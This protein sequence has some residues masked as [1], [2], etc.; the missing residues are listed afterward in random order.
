MMQKNS[1][2]V[3]FAQGI[4]SKTDPK[5]LQI[6][7]FTALQNSVFTN[8]GLLQKRNGFKT[9]ASLPGGG[10]YAYLNTFN[11]DL[12]AIGQ[13]I[14][15]YSEP[16]TSW[17]TKGNYQP[18][19]LSVLPVIRNNLNQVS[20]DIAIAPNGLGCVV[21]NEQQAS[22]SGTITYDLKFAIFDSVTGQNIV[23]P[24]LV[25]IVSGGIAPTGSAVTI[26][27][28]IF[29]NYFVIINEFSVGGN[30]KLQY[31]A[32]PW[33]TPASIGTPTSLGLE[34]NSNNV[35]WDA[36]VVPGGDLYLAY[37]W[38]TGTAVITIHIQSS[39]SVVAS[40]VISS[41]AAV[42]SLT[43]DTTSTPVIYLNYYVGSGGN[44]YMASYGPTLTPILS[45]LLTL[46]STVVVNMTASAQ[47]G[48]CFMFYE[49]TNSYGYDNA[50]PT[51]FVGSVWVN[52]GAVITPAYVVLRGVGLAS[53]SYIYSGS[54]YFLAAYS[55]P[56]QPTYFLVTGYNLTATFSTE[57]AP[58]IVAKLAYGNGGG[59]LTYG[60]PSVPVSGNTMYFGYLFKDL[61]QSVN[62]NT[63]PPAGSQVNGIYTQ[64]GINM[65][66]VVF[67][68]STIDVEEIGHDMHLSGGFLWMYDGYLPVE[69]NFFLWPDSIEVVANATVSPTG[70]VTM[71]GFTISSVSSLTNV[72]PGQFVSGTGIPS[73]TYITAVDSLGSD[74]TMSNAAT[75]SHSG[76]TLTIGG[77]EDTSYTY[78]YQVTYE[79]SDNQGNIFRSAPS[80]PVVGPSLTSQLFLHS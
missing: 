43:A 40:A 39:F 20:N 24:Q 12:T 45:P 69:H 9:L 34:P 63:N 68:S 25:P 74:I 13:N 21:Y 51:N 61:I 28:V 64:T 37:Y 26:R 35:V 73:N 11:D 15:A 5:Q 14:A 18:M 56:Y 47:N 2:K 3:N 44:S 72:A 38:A 58:N 27:V 59:Y 1:I 46:T 54:V 65:A 60:L 19:N 31:V 7:Q 48:T 41:A 4:D 76:I 30:Y 36:V 16:T 67:Q 6:G 80:I 79:W 57:A 52:S 42:I 77:N 32:I 66:T 50:I 23:A 53:K 55:S 78:Y 70:T 33:A 29:G 71:G 62:K 22:S 8:G 75:S 17:V 49:Q 10:S